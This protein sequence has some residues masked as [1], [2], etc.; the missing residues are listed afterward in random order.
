MAVMFM[1]TP[2]TN[3]LAVSIAIMQ[4]GAVMVNIPAGGSQVLT[5]GCDAIMLVNPAH[6]PHQIR[7]QNPAAVVNINPG[8]IAYISNHAADTLIQ[9]APPNGVQTTV[10][11]T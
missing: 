3:T 10:R 8:N 2:T 6:P 5:T 1:S 9:F 4:N 7:L 11:F